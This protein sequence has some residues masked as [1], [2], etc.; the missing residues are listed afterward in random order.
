MINI[1]QKLPFQIIYNCPSI[2]NRNNEYAVLNYVSSFTKQNCQLCTYYLFSSDYY[3]Y[4][5]FRL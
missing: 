4:Y 1:N 2:I 5:L 3:Y